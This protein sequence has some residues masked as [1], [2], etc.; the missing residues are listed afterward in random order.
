MHLI[1]QYIDAF[2]H[3]W[4]PH[5]CLACGTDQL[6][7][8]NVL[9]NKCIHELPYTEFANEIDNPIQ[10][11]FWGR[12]SFDF[13]NALFFFTKE[14]IVQLLIS[15]LKYKNNKKAGWMLG[16]LMGTY[17]AAYIKNNAIDCLI[18]IPIT[19]A[20]W[21]KRGYNQSTILCEGIQSI[22]GIPII[23]DVLL[24]PFESESQTHKDR[25]KRM[26][27]IGQSFVVENAWKITNKHILIIDDI[28]T[29]GATIEAAAISLEDIEI[30]KLSF[31]AAAYTI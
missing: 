12:I 24:K 19:A 30:Q 17:I 27:T 3:L 4:Y 23:E 1:E 7:K 2:V 9:C 29:T 25:V 20:K 8:K 5:N 6:E 10:K 21:K 18:P 26:D 31:F 14:S 11:I 28:L 22:T 15:E 16:R 13:A